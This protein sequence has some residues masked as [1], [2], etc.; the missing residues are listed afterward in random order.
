MNFVEQ[1]IRMVNRETGQSLSEYGLISIPI[2]VAIVLA[3]LMVYEWHGW[4][5]DHLPFI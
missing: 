1:L 2:S 3:T 4:V 5:I